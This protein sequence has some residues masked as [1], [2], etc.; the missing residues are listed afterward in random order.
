MKLVFSESKS[1]YS[2]YIF[3]YA[4]WGFPDA[5]ETPAQFFEKGFLPSSRHLDRFYLCR[6]VRVDLKK[7]RPSSENRRILMKGAGITA[8]L[9]TR[10]D[11]DYN[12]SRR[13]FMKKYADE[14]FGAN[15]MSYERL[16]SLMCSPVVSHLLVFHDEKV[17]REVGVVMLF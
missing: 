8:R 9:F 12:S 7:F 3:P 4:I 6:Q 1:D 11:F 10:G 17:G 14:K 13:E 5:G 15:V 16:D 2:H